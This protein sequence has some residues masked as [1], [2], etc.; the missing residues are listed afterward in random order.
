MNNMVDG[1]T[2]A[3]A[4]IEDNITEEINIEEISSKAYLSPFHFQRMFSILCGFPVGEYIRK[5]RLTLAGEELSTGKT[6]IIDIALKYGYE[7][8]DSFSRAFSKFHGIS[9]STAKEN[10]ARLKSFAPLKIKL[11]LEGGTMME[12]KITK[13]SAFTIMGRKKYF[14][15]ETAFKKIPE[16]WDEHFQSKYAENIKGM[17]G[18]CVNDYGKGFDY[19][20]ADLYSPWNGIPEGCETVVIPEG[21]W[22]VFTCRGKFPEIIQETDTQI[23][24]EWLPNCKEYEL[25]GSC[26]LE[27]YV[28]S[29]TTEIWIPVE[30]IEK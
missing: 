7:S 20:I 8:P 3:L 26:N 23:W 2:N 28:S 1:I 30:K 17:F 18:A 11:K 13:K 19:F 6:K 10:G 9:P 16:F 14:S 15:Q 29:D 12:Y 27:F 24:S 5:R 4:Y 25:S 22:A 21:L